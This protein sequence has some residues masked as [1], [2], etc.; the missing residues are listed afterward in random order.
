MRATHHVG[1]KGV[2]TDISRSNKQHHPR[3]V[4]Q[5][6]SEGEWACQEWNISSQ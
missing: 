5:Q 3:Q 6:D 1:Q 4:D 2:S